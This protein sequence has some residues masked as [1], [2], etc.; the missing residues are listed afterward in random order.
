[1][2]MFSLFSKKNGGPAPEEAPA[3]EAGASALTEYSPLALAFL[4]DAVYSVLVR[5][6]LM[7]LGGRPETLHAL[8]VD[9][10]RASAQSR[11]AD[12]LQ[13]YLTDAEKDI[14]RRGKGAD[15]K[16]CPSGVDK[17]TYS[18]ATGLETLFGWLYAEGRTDRAKELFDY[19]ME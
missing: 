11:A 2:S 19:C 9:A 8:S 3:R 10:V 14:Y 15:P 16:H 4:G 1:M 18:K 13:P 7:K 6:R 17:L 12:R 5:E